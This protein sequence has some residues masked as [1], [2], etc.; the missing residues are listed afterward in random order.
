MLFISQPSIWGLLLLAARLITL[1]TTNPLPAN[2][3][4]AVPPDTST[5]ATTSP[6]EIPVNTPSYLAG[7][8]PPPDFTIEA[9]VGTVELDR[10]A[11]FPLTITALGDLVGLPSDD[12]ARP[13]DYRSPDFQDMSLATSGIGPQ[14]QFLPQHMIWGLTLA[15]KYMKDQQQ[16]RNWRFTLQWQG[17]V[18]GTLLYLYTS[19][20]DTIESSATPSAG[21][22]WQPDAPISAHGIPVDDAV[23]TTEIYAVESVQIEYEDAMMVLVSGMTDLAMH[24]MDEPVV[25]Y[26]FDTTW[27]PYACWFLLNPSKVTPGSLPPRWFR[28]NRVRQLIL[29]LSSEYSSPLS[30]MCHI[31]YRGTCRAARIKMR[32]SDVTVCGGALTNRPA[33][34]VG[35]VN[36]IENVTSS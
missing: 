7:T 14:S 20:G 12:Q 33:L 9:T 8:L 17:N 18:V 25:G 13:R 35:A 19:P 34:L 22:L 32:S 2:E 11:V 5:I 36:K 6:G 24:R 10:R 3:V 29:R 1:V 4:N 27:L 30:L 15:V 21:D 26:H 23:V 16:F 28:Y 31:P